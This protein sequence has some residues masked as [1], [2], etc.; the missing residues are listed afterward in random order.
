V[1]AERL[2][3]GWY[4]VKE[5]VEDEWEPARFISRWRTIAF[6]EGLREPPAIIGPRIEPPADS[7]EG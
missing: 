1:S 7:G 3:P 6:P 4:W 5:Y 2:E